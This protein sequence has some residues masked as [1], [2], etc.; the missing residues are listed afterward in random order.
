MLALFI[1]YACALSGVLVAA[2]GLILW[3]WRIPRRP[4][5]S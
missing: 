5:L 4:P 1:V 3:D 2:V